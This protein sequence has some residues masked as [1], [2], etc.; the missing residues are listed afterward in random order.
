MDRNL[1]DYLVDAED[2]GYEKPKKSFSK[3]LVQGLAGAL[4]LIRK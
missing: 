2:L 1:E 4:E 3:K